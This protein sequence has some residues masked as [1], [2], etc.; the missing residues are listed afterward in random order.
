MPNLTP[1]DLAEGLAKG[2]DMALHGIGRMTLAES[3]FSDWCRK[4]GPTALRE[5]AALRAFHESVIDAVRTYD[6]DRQAH[7]P[8][9]AARGLALFHAIEEALIGTGAIALRE[10]V[11]GYP[12]P[13]VLKLYKQAAHENGELF[14]WCVQN[15]EKFPPI[16]GDWLDEVKR[17]LK[18]L[19]A[20]R[21]ERAALVA[22]WREVVEDV[23]RRGEFLNA[24][25]IK[26]CADQLAALDKPEGV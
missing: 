12:S 16:E 14:C 20:E 21:A 18:Q 9:D 5:L 8:P 3:Q 4:H 22:V 19:T 24:S 7:I 10:Q 17:R 15:L 23:I 26:T 2:A 11:A 1:A 6:D 25:S 13:E